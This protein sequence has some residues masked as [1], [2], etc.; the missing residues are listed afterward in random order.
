M[1]KHVQFVLYVIA[2]ICQKLLPVDRRFHDRLQV[3][4]TQTCVFGE[5][6]LNDNLDGT[7]KKSACLLGLMCICTCVLPELNET[8]LALEKLSLVS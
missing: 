6:A 8:T 3:T 4:E 7:D 2:I 5:T 1:K